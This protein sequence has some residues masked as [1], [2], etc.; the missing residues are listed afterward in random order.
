MPLPYTTL[1]YC[2]FL[3][4]ASL[5]AQDS[6]TLI[7]PQYVFDGTTLHEDLAVLLLHDTI[8]QV[9]E[10]GSL[11]APA[12]CTV[13][14]FPG[15]TL[16]PGMIEGHAHL[17]LHP[18]NET[19]WT[20]QVLLESHAERAI[21]GGE[22]ARRTLQA[23]F[24]TVRDLGSEGAGYA[25]VGLKQAIEKGVIP[26]P[27]LLV[28]GKAIV[29]TGSY[30]PG[31]Y[32]EHVTVP[33]GAEVA[34]GQDELT[35]VVRDQIGHGA[36]VIKVY[37]DYRWGPDGSAQPTF[38]ERELALI[39]ELAESS[40]RPVV[41]HAATAEGMRRATLAGVSTIEHGDGGTPEVFAL[42]AERGVALCPTL[43][44][45]D[46]ILQYRGWHKDTDPEPERVVQKR[47]SFSDALAAGVTIVAGGDVGVFP[48][49]D[50]VRELELMVDYGMSPLE[51]LRSVTSGNADVFDLADRLGR[52]TPGLLADLVIVQGDPTTDIS[53]L[54]Q[55][56]YVMQKGVP[57]PLP[58]P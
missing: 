44:A 34:D 22:H 1:S 53:A 7:T 16:L 48:H 33:L 49:G 39:V 20:D 15:G 23:G 57:V 54:R 55:V 30:G 24:T 13:R 32:A 25:D 14:D 19:S 52:I 37:A 42:M 10:A 38:T 56:V 11:R 26:G 9:A 29:A 6:C 46:A 2:L 40:G 18:Y 41:A 45:G 43:A 51:V 5:T 21:R 17:L 58:H 4:C 47:Q 35:R 27:R 36:D 28:A 8:A 50:N 3:L 12:G 31:G